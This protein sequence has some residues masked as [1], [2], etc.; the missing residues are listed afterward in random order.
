MGPR[1]WL[2]QNKLSGDMVPH[3]VR[4]LLEALK[5]IK[6]ALLT[7][8]DRKGPESGTKSSDSTKRK[9]ISFDERNPMRCCK[10]KHYLLCK[11]TPGHI[12]NP[13]HFGLPE[14]PI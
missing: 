13:Q 3:S 7:N 10:E 11:A 9:M 4:K 5:Q 2:D 12:H 8:K 6:K 1:N 14:V